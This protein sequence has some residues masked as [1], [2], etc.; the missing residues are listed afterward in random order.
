[1]RFT[2]SAK[3]EWAQAR[4][5]A[6][7]DAFEA[8][9][10]AG[11]RER[12]TAQW[13]DAWVFFLPGLVI[14]TVVAQAIAGPRGAT[15]GEWLTLAT[16]P[17]LE[18]A[19]QTLFVRDGI[20]LTPGREAK[21]IAIVDASSGQRLS[22]ARAYVRCVLSLLGSLLIV[23][24]AILVFTR[25]KQSVADL[26]V[27]TVV[28]RYEQAAPV[29]PAAAKRRALWINLA[30]IAAIIGIGTL[31]F[32]PFFS[33]MLENDRLIPIRNDLVSYADRLEAYSH[34]HGAMPPSL[35]SLGYSPESY[36]TVY[37]LTPAGVLYAEFT[38]G[39][40]WNSHKSY[41]SL[42]PESEEATGALRWHCRSLGISKPLR[43]NC[44]DSQMADP[45]WVG[46]R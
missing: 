9:D 3:M 22:F 40:W 2:S 24:N 16:I 11:F 1:M 25:R 4:S 23:P 41:Y 36:N 39:P 5:R 20:R 31:A 17:A 19:Y 6:I 30:L 21:R 45:S 26:L 34:E 46:K 14:A 42:Y 10:W 33:L 37:I 8:G 13:M 44:P 28:V 12:L 32:G 29:V 18:A 15:L 27:H 43:R 35:S 38:N 7:L